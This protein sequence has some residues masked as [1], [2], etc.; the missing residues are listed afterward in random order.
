MG[1][2][3]INEKYVAMGEHDRRAGESRISMEA[4]DRG[5]RVAVLAN[6]ALLRP[7]RRTRTLLPEFAAMRARKPGCDRAADLVAL[8]DD[9]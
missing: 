2:I 9:R 4:R 8:R 5:Q 6:P 7:R 1:S 3:T